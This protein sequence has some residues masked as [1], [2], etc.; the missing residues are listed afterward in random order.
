MV[1]VIGHDRYINILTWLYEAF[2]ANF[3]IWC[4][5]LCFQVSFGNIV[6]QKKL[7]KFAILTRKPRIR[8]RILI[9]RSWLIQRA[10]ILIKLRKLST[11][12]NFLYQITFLLS[13]DHSVKRAKSLIKSFAYIRITYLVFKANKQV[14]RAVL[15]GNTSFVLRGVLLPL[16]LVQS[17]LFTTTKSFFFTIKLC[18]CTTA[19]E[20]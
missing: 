12:L 5:F 20:S 4:C 15:W 17:V 13:F 8:V 7:K 19:N 1:D 18:I 14:L 6:R 3:Y 9:Y 10:E 2:R 11:V 16:N